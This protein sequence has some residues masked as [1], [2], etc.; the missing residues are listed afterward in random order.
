MIVTITWL[1]K[2][3]IVKKLKDNSFFVIAKALKNG[4]KLS[5]DNDIQLIVYSILE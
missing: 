1:L 4:G 2:N 5:S 3:E